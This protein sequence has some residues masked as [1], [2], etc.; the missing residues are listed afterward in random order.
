MIPKVKEIRYKIPSEKYTDDK[1]I[2]WRYF[3]TQHRTLMCKLP[4]GKVQKHQQFSMSNHT[5]IAK[6]MRKKM[7]EGEYKRPVDNISWNAKEAKP[8]LKCRHVCGKPTTAEP[9][10]PPHHMMN[11]VKE[12]KMKCP[13]TSVEEPQNLG[14]W[15]CANNVKG[16]NKITAATLDHNL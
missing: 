11:D 1:D 5:V 8:R 14:C 12:S 4:N 2:V 3:P 9:S 10:A 15:V 13:S 16:D 7:N 6:R